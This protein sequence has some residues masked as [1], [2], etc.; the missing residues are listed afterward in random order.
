MIYARLTHTR[1][2][3]RFLIRY[4]V[5][6]KVNY[7]NLTT[8]LRLIFQHDDFKMWI[9]NPSRYNIKTFNPKLMLNLTWFLI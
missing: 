6:L 4:S 3:M 2:L 5:F 1:L 9:S 7:T 8:F